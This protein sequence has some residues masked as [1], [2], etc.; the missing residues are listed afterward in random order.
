VAEERSLDGHPMQSCAARRRKTD[1]ELAEEFWADIGYPTPASRVWE[2][3]PCR[4]SGEVLPVCRSD[5]LEG[6]APEEEPA[7]VVVAPV[8]AADKAAP[9]ETFRPAARGVRGVPALARAL[10]RPWVGPIPPPR[11]SPPRTL[12][13]LLPP[14]CLG[15]AAASSEFIA[16]PLP[17]G[18]AVQPASTTVVQSLDP[19]SSAA[20]ILASDPMHPVRPLRMANLGRWLGHLW[21]R[22][23]TAG[24]PNLT[25]SFA[26]VVR[27][28]TMSRRDPSAPPGG[29]AGNQAQPSLRAAQQPDGPMASPA[30]GA[31]GFAPGVYQPIQTPSSGAPSASFTPVQ[32]PPGQQLQMQAYQGQFPH[33]FV[34][35]ST[36]FVQQQPVHLQPPGGYVQQH[37]QPAI[38]SYQPNAIAYQ[39]QQGHLAGAN[40]QQHMQPAS[41][42]NAGQAI[43]SPAGPVAARPRKPKGGKG[44]RPKHHHGLA[45]QPT[46]PMQATVGPSMPPPA[47]VYIPASS[48]TV[49]AGHGLVAPVHLGAHPH[50]QPVPSAGTSEVAAAPKKLWCTKCQSAGHLSDDCNTQQYCFICNKTNH[51]MTMRRCPALKLPKPTAMLC[52]YGTENM[53]FFQMPDNVCREDL[54]PLVSPTALVSISGGSISHNIVEAEVAKIAQFQQQWTWEAI[55][56]GK[57]AF[58]MSFPSEEVLQRVTGFAVFIKSHN[59]TIEFKPWKEDVQHRFELVPIW[60]HVHGVPHALRHFLGLWAVGSVIGATL[61]VDLL[62]LRRR[63]IIRIQVAV[64]NLD[65]FNRSTINSLSSDVVVERKGYEFRYSLEEPD[66]PVDADFVP[67]VW[68]HGDDPGGDMGHDREDTAGGNES[69]RPKPATSSNESSMAPTSGG[70]MPMQLSMSSGRSSPP[71]KTLCIAVTPPNPHR[72]SSPKAVSSPP[73]RSSSS[74]TMPPA[75]PTVA[76]LIA[77]PPASSTAST[78]RAPTTP[79]SPALVTPYRLDEGSLARTHLQG[80]A[81]AAAAPCASSPMPSPTIPRRGVVFSP[82]VQADRDSAMAELRALSSSP[83]SPGEV[84]VSRASTPPTPSPPLEVAEGEMLPS[85]PSSPSPHSPTP[86]LGDVGRVA[87]NDSTPSPLR[88]SGRHSIGADGT[89]STD[90]DSLTRAMRRA[91]TR[92]LDYEGTSSRKSFLSFDNSRVSANIASLGVSLGRNEKEVQVSVK[93]LKQM[94]FDRLTVAPRLSTYSDSLVSDEEDEDANADHDGKLLSHLVNDK[95]EV[96][97]EDTVRDTMLCELVASVRKNKSS[98]AK[99]RGRPSKRANVPK[100]KYGSS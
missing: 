40:Q 18:L 81:T 7:E 83:S 46:A 62:C 16:S 86:P 50:Q 74:A 78:P 37:H 14:R 95:T 2:R 6:S 92:N 93:A 52:G 76:P 26:A 71:D 47:P 77:T 51:P 84:T 60:V 82:A 24:N 9:G 68:E 43:T 58:L 54:S 97:L 61:D 23:R 45:H 48:S 94:E 75:S 63:G 17:S 88:R 32:Q 27:S 22:G 31:P 42:F 13:D 56:H 36:P 91:A 20:P 64:L 96:D 66:F 12:G 67:R 79:A 44:G 25:R 3:P 70:V 89:T 34:G 85:G 59:V 39:Q 38:A 28:P 80:E 19:V 10:V 90:E 72:R 55:P 99:K 4:R 1:A 29:A 5:A 87:A 41:S 35:I 73:A 8:P 49:A 11:R 100:Y 53:A 30:G 15:D 69:K 98:S 33:Q 57:D 21:K 65:A